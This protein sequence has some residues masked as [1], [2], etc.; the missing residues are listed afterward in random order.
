M[1]FKIP[2]LTS[3]QNVNKLF[4]NNLARGIDDGDA[5][6]A[7]GDDDDAD[8]D[9]GGDEWCPGCHQSEN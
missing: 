8:G 3:T 6:S 5:H 4:G 2:C 7:D 1:H 9:D